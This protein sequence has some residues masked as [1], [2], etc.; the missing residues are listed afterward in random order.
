[1]SILGSSNFVFS[2]IS[3]RVFGVTGPTGPVG[4]TGATG[5]TGPLVRGATGNTGYG[6]TGFTST[7]SNILTI[8]LGDTGTIQINI[9][10]ATSEYE[11][12]YAVVK[13][14][15]TNGISVLYH[16]NEV[17]KSQNLLEL[18]KTDYLKIKGITFRSSTGSIES[19]SVTSNQIIVQGKTYNFFPVGETGNIAYIYT[20]TKAKG[21]PNS[22]WDATTQTLRIPLAGERITL[23]NTK[24]FNETLANLTQDI[25]GYTGATGIAVPVYSYSPDIGYNV[26]K[27]RFEEK[28]NNT[29]NG[30]T[31]TPNLFIGSSGGVDLDYKFLP[32]TIKKNSIFTPQVIGATGN[33]GSCCFCALNETVSD[34]KCLDYVTKQYCYDMGGSFSTVECVKRYVSSLENGSGDCFAEGACCV[35][36][37]CISTSQELCLK[38]NGIFYP[39]EV[40]HPV[41]GSIGEGYFNCPSYCPLDD[42]TGKCCVKGKCYDDITSFACESIPNSSFHP[43]ESCDGDCDPDCLDTLRG[44]C[45]KADG[46]ECNDGYT[47]VECKESGG[48]F[49]GP[50]EVC[51]LNSCCGNNFRGEYFN[52]SEACKYSELIPCL[53]IGTYVGGGYLV[54]IVGAPSPCS[55]YSNPLVAEGQPLSCRYFPRGFMPTDPTWKYKNCFGESGVTF[56][57]TSLPPSSLNI[58]YFTRTYP[59]VL[60]EDKQRINSCLLKAGLPFIMQTYEGVARQTATLNTPVEW[61]D[62]I[63]F[64]D[65]LEYDIRNGTFSYSLEHLSNISMFEP[66]GFVGSSTYLKLAKQ[67]YGETQIH[68]LWAI[69]VAPEDIEI[70]GSKNLSWGISESRVRGN[71]EFGYNLEP[72]STCMIDGLLTTRMHDE[73]SKENTYFWF[74]DLAE[75]DSNTGVDAL[76]FDRFVFYSNGAYPNSKWQNNTIENTIETNENEFK[77]SYAILWDNMTDSDSCMKQISVLN[78]TG[79]NGYNDWYVPSIIELNHI[80]GNLT[81]LNTAIALNGDDVFAAQKYWSSSSMCTLH[82]W[83]VNNH[84]DKKYYEIFETPS[85]EFNSKFRFTKNDFNLTED[86]LYDLSMNACAGEKMLTQNFSNGF[87]ESQNRDSKVAR[88]RPI[89]RIPI[90]VYEDSS[91]SIKLAEDDFNYNSCPSCPDRTT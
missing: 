37:E 38:Y 17:Q 11:N 91:Y 68:M 13:G 18:G 57:T 30:F 4:I 5:I 79:L 6:I 77:N 36:G 65:N 20:P 3:T 24:N 39:N 58:K 10:G 40:C 47:P 67:F 48:I 62:G 70:S 44:G 60:T 23:Y 84:L 16:Y 69:I 45:C 42:Q 8:F 32:V 12:Q 21:V 71:G 56:G 14:V 86:K 28:I 78:Q 90:L 75:N 27:Q 26:N 7:S 41:R 74:R 52:S 89:R 64:K 2:T 73:T 53:P 85:G 49:L 25:V 9:Q 51:G 31:Y 82:K 63:M 80:Y 29:L 61:D 55:V 50:G 22:Y 59:E 33:I 72:I 87:V 46:S 15:T 81:E 35:N 88:L 34:I 76:A 54:G 83:N 1:M 19:V 66:L 43:G